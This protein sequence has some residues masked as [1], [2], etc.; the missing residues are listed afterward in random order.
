MVTTLSIQE[1]EADARAARSAAQAGPVLIADDG[2]P[3]NV[4]MTAEEYQRLTG[5]KISIVDL[6]ALPPGTPDVELDIPARRE[7]ARAAD[8]S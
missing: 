3:A 8:L 1:F 5:R 6:I 4:L 2:V 7:P